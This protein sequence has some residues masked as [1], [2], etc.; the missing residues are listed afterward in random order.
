MATDRN[1]DE[2]LSDEGL[3]EL[4]DSDE[5]GQVGRNLK[6]FRPEDMQN[7]IFKIGMKFASVEF[8][9][10]A[11]IEYSIKQ[12]VEIKMPNNDRTKIKAH[13]DVGC[14]WYLFASFDSRMKCFLI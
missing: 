14:P 3:L 7:P 2:L 9:R 5:E 8:L 10:M 13:C 11:I 12:W 6:T 1:W 4:P